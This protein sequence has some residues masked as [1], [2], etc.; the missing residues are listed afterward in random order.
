MDRVDR[1]KTFK[2]SGF[3]LSNLKSCQ[4]CPSLLIVFSPARTRSLTLA[5]LF[6]LLLAGCARGGGDPVISPDTARRELFLRGY[7]YKPAVFLDAAKDGD[8]LGVKLFL[9]A[10]MSPEVRNDAGETPLLLAARYDHAQAARALLERGADVNARDKRGFTPLMRAVLNGSMET[11]QT[12]TEFK[13]D[14]NA[15]TTDPDPN[16]SGSTALMYAVAKDRKDV[17]DMLL[18]AGADI[19]ES[20]VVV[21]PALT[22]AAAYDREEIA[23]DLLER[24]ADANVVN[25]VGGTPLIVAASKGNPRLVRMLLDHGADPLWKMKDGK[26]ALQVAQETRRADA[27]KVLQEAVAAKKKRPGEGAQTK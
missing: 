26:N 20:D 27:L 7:D 19:N 23:A 22:W 3:V 16:T 8:T 18:D 14:L 10:G 15:Q 25:N 12:I 1:I 9:I 13:P 4:S 21:G 6:C 5:V 2:A 11:V 17:L 24:G